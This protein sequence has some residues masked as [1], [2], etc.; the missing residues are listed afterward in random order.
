MRFELVPWHWWWSE[1]E[2]QR[3]QLGCPFV[4]VDI[5]AWHCV[6]C[7][8]SVDPHSKMDQ[9]WDGTFVFSLSSYTKRRVHTQH[10]GMSQSLRTPM[11]FHGWL[12]DW[13]N[14]AC[15]LF[16]F[17]WKTI[18][19]SCL[20]SCFCMK[21]HHYAHRWAGFGRVWSVFFREVWIFKVRRLWSKN[22]VRR[23][24]DTSSYS[25]NQST[26]E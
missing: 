24:W 14:V 23:L 26:I 22:G 11:L 3:F 15:T 12:I 25:I 17:F 8:Q 6:Q 7:W 2:H 18:I 4:V 21:N 1:R 9:L 5:L 19:N 10:E 16:S 13:L 20:H